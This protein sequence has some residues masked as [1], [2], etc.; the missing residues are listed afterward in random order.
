MIAKAKIKVKSKTRATTSVPT[1]IKKK[2]IA[3]SLTKKIAALGTG[4]AALGAA[5]YYLFGPKGDKHQRKLKDFAIKTEKEA[6]REVKKIA[7]QTQKPKKATKR[8]IAKK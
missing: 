4:V 7:F 5:T 3:S 6:L 2:K 1:E 8:A